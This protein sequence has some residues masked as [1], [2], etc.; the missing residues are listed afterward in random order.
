MKSS[1]FRAV[2]TIPLLV[3]AMLLILGSLMMYAQRPRVKADLSELLPAEQPLAHAHL[4]A[5]RENLPNVLRRKPYRHILASPAFQ[6][7]RQTPEWQKFAESFP[8]KFPINPMRFVGK[9]TVFGMYE[10]GKNETIPALLLLSRVD[11][12]A[13]KTE[14]LLYAAN[15]FTWKQRITVAQ[16]GTPFALYRLQTADMLFPLYY[17]VIDDVFFLSTSLPLLDATVKNATTANA[18]PVRKKRADQ[19]L[20][21]VDLRPAELLQT[22]ARSPLF[23]ID[24]ETLSAIAPDTEFA[25]SL[26]ALPEEIRLEAILSRARTPRAEIPRQSVPPVLDNDAAIFIGLNRDET[27]QMLTRLHA[28]FPKMESA[29][30][31]PEIAALQAITDGRLECRSSSRVAGMVYAVP[32]MSCLTVFQAAPDVAMAMMRQTVTQLLV[33]S[34]PKGQRNLVKQFDETYKNAAL[35]RVAL[36]IQEILAYG[37]APA[38][39]NGYGVFGASSKTLKREMDRLFALEQASPYRM[40]TERGAALD[41]IVQPP[42]LAD[43]LKNLAQTPTFSLLLPKSQHPQLYASLP[44]IL[45][46]LNALPPVMLDAQ[47][48]GESLMY[49][50]RLF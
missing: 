13:R 29:E 9:D 16:P 44:L 20:V 27:A 40:T 5:L 21:S 35:V 23:D 47:L 17:A 30:L 7:L 15:A 3:A 38:H 18:A 48:D 1:N 39:A 45:L 46:A 37:V 25:L 22:L 12:L 42:Q 2:W 36:L 28:M 14:Q 19:P 33:Q 4:A 32:D 10:T 26:N 34:I 11:W 6:E 49:S 50:L 43:L 24:P 8:T 41:L 31:L